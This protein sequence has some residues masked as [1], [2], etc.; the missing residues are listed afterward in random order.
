MSLSNIPL[1]YCVPQTDSKVIEKWM[2]GA[3][4]FLMEEPAVPGDDEATKAA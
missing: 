1:C 4:D 2:E 3:Q